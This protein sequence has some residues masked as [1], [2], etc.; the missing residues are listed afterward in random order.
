MMSCHVQLSDYQV[1][2]IHS[3]EIFVFRTAIA[4]FSSLHKIPGRAKILGEIQKLT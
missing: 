2:C 1:G 3:Q 4:Y